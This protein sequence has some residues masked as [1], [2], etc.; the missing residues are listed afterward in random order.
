MDV[1]DMLI[2]PPFTTTTRLDQNS[3]ADTM[4]LSRA[5]CCVIIV[6][7]C[8]QFIILRSHIIIVHCAY[9]RYI[10]PNSRRARAAAEMRYTIICIARGGQKR[11]FSL[12]GDQIE[13]KCRPTSRGEVAVH[14]FEDLLERTIY[15]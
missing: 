1:N 12:H 6:G 8:F 2:S 11:L 3:C 4:P 15:I 7:R 5:G 10:W 13:M 14:R 9:L